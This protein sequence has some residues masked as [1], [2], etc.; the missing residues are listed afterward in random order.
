MSRVW[1]TADTNFMNGAVAMAR[2]FRSREEHD[3]EVVR[4]W[5][6]L[7]AHDDQ[8]WHLGDVGAGEPLLALRHIPRLNGVIHLIAGEC[9]AVWSGNRKGH[10]H[11]AQWLMTFA[12]IQTFAVRRI[13][14]HD[15]L[16]T[17]FPCR[18]TSFDAQAETSDVDPYAPFRHRD[19]GG[20]LLHG[21]VRDAWKTH[22]SQ[23]N[24]G[25]DHWD[26]APVLADRVADLVVTVSTGV[27]K[28]DS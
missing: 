21:H 9:D 25:L 7:V 12:S 14:G 26:F 6:E 27:S 11:Q 22:G 20:V 23:I 19:T 18:D 16:L 4:R 5:N 15:I 1:F 3:E 28:A 10:L 24:V 8:V 2:G 13:R 17:H